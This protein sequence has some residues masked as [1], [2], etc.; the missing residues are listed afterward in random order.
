MV[1]TRN[2]TLATNNSN[3]FG[4]ISGPQSNDSVQ[5]NEYRKRGVKVYLTGHVPPGRKFYYP[6]CFRRYTL[7]SHAFRDVILGHF[8]GHNNMDHFFLLD[9]KQALEEEEEAE[10]LKRMLTEEVDLNALSDDELEI[11]D[12]LSTRDASTLLDSHHDE[13]KILGAEEYMADLKDM[14]SGLPSKPKPKK[15]KKGKKGE[16]QR[17]KWEKKVREYEENYQIVQVAPSI[18]PAYYSGIRVFEYNVSEL[19]GMKFM[20]GMDENVQR[21]NWTE[22]WIQM[23]MQVAAEKAEQKNER[24]HGGLNF[25]NSIEE[26]QFLDDDDIIREYQE[27]IIQ[28]KPKKPP[29]MHIPPGP[30]KS[31]PRGPLFEPQLFTPTRWEVHF[32]NLTEVNAVF[33]EHPKKSWDYKE[34]FKLEYASDGAPYHMRDLTVDA[35][36]ELARNIGKEKKAGKSEMTD[37]V[38]LNQ[39]ND[40]IRDS[41]ESDVDEDLKKGR[42]KKKKKGGKGKGEKG[43]HEKKT[44][45]YWDV[46]LRRAFVNSGHHVDLDV[47]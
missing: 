21:V 41:E 1:A 34:F 45:T 27:P 38:E 13:L 39:A 22:W 37:S 29:P 18:I 35:W 47:E 8:Y 3:G 12:R 17:K 16:K 40:D 5:L 25:Q 19:V 36:L 6:S 14:F 43:K 44:E 9:A 2:L 42:G 15:W 30:H 31:A 26:A 4:K 20:R 33:T 46:F 10:M 24:Y 28:K 23:D 11:L 32:V 7:W